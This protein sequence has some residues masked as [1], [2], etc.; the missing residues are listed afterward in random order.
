MVSFN[1][2]VRSD[3]QDE[4][5]VLSYDYWHELNG[6]EVNEWWHS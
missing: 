5:L 2:D 6:T 3:R 1:R 4:M